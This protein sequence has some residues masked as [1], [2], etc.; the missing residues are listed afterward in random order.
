MSLRYL[1]RLFTTAVRQGKDPVLIVVF[2]G[3]RLE[4]RLSRPRHE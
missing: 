4:C 2:P 1:E 3:L